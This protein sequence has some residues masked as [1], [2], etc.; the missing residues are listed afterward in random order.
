MLIDKIKTS[1]RV[2]HDQLDDEINDLISAAKLDL[3][4]SGVNRIDET[5]ALIIR[6]VTVYCK[7][8]FGLFNDDSVKYERAYNLLKNHLTLCGDY[9]VQ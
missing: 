5:D 2:S 4:I 7:A 6:A 1:L 8:H 3:S 9:D